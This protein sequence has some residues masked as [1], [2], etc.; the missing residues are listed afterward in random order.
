MKRHISHHKKMLASMRDLRDRKEES[1][2][3]LAQ[4]IVELQKQIDLLEDQVQQAADAGLLR[5]DAEIFRVRPSS[6]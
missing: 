5:F 1:R 4:E 6:R 3:R 2:T